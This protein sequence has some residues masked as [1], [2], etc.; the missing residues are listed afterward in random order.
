MPAVK[1][2]VQ[3]SGTVTS[4][5]SIDARKEKVVSSTLV[6]FMVVDGKDGDLFGL[7]S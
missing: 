4:C 3:V 2:A 6:D 7:P 5:A 1:P